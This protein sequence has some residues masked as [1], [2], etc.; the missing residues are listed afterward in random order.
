MAL[1]VEMAV[2]RVVCPVELVQTLSLIRFCVDCSPTWLMSLTTMELGSD[3]V[4][5]GW[6][7]SRMIALYIPMYCMPFV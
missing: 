1:Q 5:H 2:S 4:Q 7:S 3:E 6:K